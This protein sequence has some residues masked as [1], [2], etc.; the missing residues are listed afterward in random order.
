[1]HWM[2]HGRFYEI[3]RWRRHGRSDSGRDVHVFVGDAFEP[4]GALSI[5]V[6]ASADYPPIYPFFLAGIGLN[7][8]F[9]MKPLSVPTVFRTTVKKG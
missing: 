1:M 5:S 2:S 9:E 6:T 3:V 4:A 7:H 8:N